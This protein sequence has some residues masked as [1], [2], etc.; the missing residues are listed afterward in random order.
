M[1]NSDHARNVTQKNKS[2]LIGED[3]PL[4]KEQELY[5]I[6]DNDAYK[7]Y[8]KKKKK[9]W[10]STCLVACEI[11]AL[12][13]VNVVSWVARNSE[14][15]SEATAIT[16]PAGRAWESRAGQFLVPGVNRQTNKGRKNTS[17]T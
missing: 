11:L 14:K 4:T 1:Y 16:G 13:M 6:C 7:F 10:L 8:T 2:H 15:P 17:S 12:L 5:I 3:K 9:S